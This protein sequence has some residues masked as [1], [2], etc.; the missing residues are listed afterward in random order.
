[1]P[2]ATAHILKSRMTGKHVPSPSKGVTSGSG[3]AGG[4]CPERSR[5]M[6]DRPAGGGA[7]IVP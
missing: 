2:M 1:M 7:G 5:R 6:G 3:V 4:A